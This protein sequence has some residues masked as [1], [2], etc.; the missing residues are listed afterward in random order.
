[1]VYLKSSYSALD[2][3]KTLLMD[4]ISGNFPIALQCHPTHRGR[5]LRE[6]CNSCEEEE[7]GE[8]KGLLVYYVNVV[9][10]KISFVGLGF[11]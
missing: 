11:F 9:G 7:S 10:C 5:G 8:V 2:F 1:M 4:P 6:E 3:L